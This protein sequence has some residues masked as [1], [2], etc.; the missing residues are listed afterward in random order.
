M[1]FDADGGPARRRGRPASCSPWPTSWPTRITTAKKR[2][3]GVLDFNDLL[4]RA[5]N[6][7][8]GPEH[9][10][11]A[12]AA[13]R[14][15]PPAAG[16]R[17]PGHRSAAGRAGQG[18]VRQR[19]PA[20]QA[21][22][23]GRL[24]AVDLPLPRRRSARVPAAARRDARGGPA[25]AV[26][27]L[28]Q[29]AG[30]A[31]LRQRAVLRRAGAGLRAAAAAPPAGRPD[32]GRRVPVGDRCRRWQRRGESPTAAERR[33]DSATDDMR[34]ARAAATAR[35]R[36][37]RPAHPRACSTRGEKIVCGSTRRPTRR[38]DSRRSGR[39]G[40]GDIAMLFRALSNVEYYEE[41]LRRYG[42]DYYLVGGHAFYAQQEIFDLLNLLRALDS[43]GDEVSLAGVL[44]SP[45]FG[46]F[47][48][49]LFWLSQHPGGLAAG[50]FDARS[51]R[52][53]LDD[54]QR[55]PRRVRRGHAPR[56]AGD[57]G[58]PADRP[59]DP[60]GARPHRLRRRAAGRVS[61]RA[62]A[63]QPAQADRAGA[64]LRPGGHLHA[65]RLHHAAFRVRRPPA[66]RA[67]GRHAPRIDRRGA[68]DDDSP[69]EGA[70]VSRGDR[71]RRGPAARDARGPSVRLHAAAGADVQGARTPRPATTST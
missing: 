52:A 9:R 27:E 62:E 34:T 28:P 29:P 20:R 67:A 37:D 63:G 53:E 1:H 40:R 2:E 23:R 51:C 6:L 56:P 42:I 17:V 55:P 31:G 54:Q 21:V 38:G 12:Q 49:T 3:L 32:A 50:L 25:A 66:R 26:A 57:E 16:R 44:R 19:A 15:D 10:R 69:V 59:A 22:L 8:V 36:L 48:E 4:I 13:G 41:A 7:L 45:F 14:A 60:R 43:P 5:R 39:C 35:G 24:Q 68:A 58:P 70:G 64:E 11:P 61:R 65:G 30:G 33:R 46:L 71:A 47:D 18:A